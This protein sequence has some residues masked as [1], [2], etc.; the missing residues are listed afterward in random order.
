M[1]DGQRRILSRIMFALVC[2][3]RTHF[4]YLFHRRSWVADIV[5]KSIFLSFSLVLGSFEEAVLSYFL[6]CK[7]SKRRSYLKPHPLLNS[8]GICVSIWDD[9]LNFYFVLYFV[10]RGIILFKSISLLLQLLLSSFSL[11]WANSTNVTKI[12]K[13]TQNP[14][15]YNA[16]IFHNLFF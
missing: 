10:F 2:F 13:L 7:E 11:L 8:E 5:L 15:S 9:F 14:L 4:F 16:L 3:P 6:C 12:K 1:N